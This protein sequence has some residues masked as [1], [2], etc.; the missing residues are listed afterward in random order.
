MVVFKCVCVLGGK[1]NQKNGKSWEKETINGWFLKKN[2]KKTKV[3]KEQL[4]FVKKK[5]RRQ[6]VLSLYRLDYAFA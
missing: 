6:H 2:K 1:I 3:C 4:Q 5:K